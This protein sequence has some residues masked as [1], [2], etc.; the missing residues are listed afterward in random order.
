MNRPISE[1]VYY[2]LANALSAGVASFL[3]DER[4]RDKNA[5]ELWKS[6]L[7]HYHHIDSGYNRFL[8]SL[9][10]LL[11][12][13]LMHNGDAPDFYNDYKKGIN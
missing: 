4:Q 10:D 13:R 11:A 2:R 5:Y 7:N 3:I 6:I 8:I 9:R 1:T 12:L